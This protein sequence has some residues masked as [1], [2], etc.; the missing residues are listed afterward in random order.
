[1]KAS[2]KLNEFEKFRSEKILYKAMEY[3]VKDI[4]LEDGRPVM[5]CMTIG[6]GS[7]RNA[8][9]WLDEISLS[10]ITNL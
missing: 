6:D 5:K 1:M 3:Q 4:L 9:L 2:D 8:N 10:E 7:K